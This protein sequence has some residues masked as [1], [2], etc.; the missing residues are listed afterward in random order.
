METRHAVDL[1]KILETI[2]ADKKEMAQK[3]QAMQEQIQ[4]LLISQ[5]HGEDSASS[6]S[7]NKR[8]A[9]S[10]HPNDIKVDIPEYDGKLDP[11]EFVEW[12][13]TVE[14]VFDCKQTTEDN[15]V[16]IVALK[17]RLG[18]IASE[19]PNKRMISLADFELA[20]GFEFESDLV[21][22]P[23]SPHDDKVEVT[24][25]DEGEPLGTE[26]LMV[27]S[28]IDEVAEL[29]V[30][31]GE[32]LWEVNEEWLIAP[33][34]PPLMPDIPTLST[35]KVGGPSTVAVEG[36]SFALLA[37][38]FPV[39]PSVIKD[40]CTRM[41]NLDYGHGQPVKKVIHLSD[42]EVADGISIRE[43]IP[44]VSAIEGHVQVMMS[45]MVQVVGKLEKVG[46]QIEQGQQATTQQDETIEGLSQQVQTLQAAVQQRDMQIQ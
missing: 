43:I 4:E 1:K 14:R 22:S 17:L 9:G 33:V 26:E 39:P 36:H 37:T 15:K 42:A 7:V 28:M 16:K 34:T 44:R 5:N 24:G 23:E 38:G 3:M 10:W 12:L 29:M 6:G 35:Y 13:R 2:E 21:T 40:L 32:E 19:C 46:T 8:G 41:G 30:E 11:D 20:G 18:H 45:Q 31:D 27:D 25:P